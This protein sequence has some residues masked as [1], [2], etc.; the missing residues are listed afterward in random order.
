MIDPPRIELAR[1][2]TPID[3]LQDL[4]TELGVE[5]YVKRDDLTGAALSG[6]KVRK[7]EYVL[8]QALE[9]DADVVLTCGGGQS[10][11]CRATAIAARRVGLDVELFLREARDTPVDGNL[12]LDLLV[13]AAIHNLTDT[14]YADVDQIMADRA[15][16]LGAQGRDAYVIPEGAS[17]A[18]GSLGYVRCM[19]EIRAEEDDADLRFDV[20]VVPVGSG[21]T[22]AG[23][24]AGAQ[25]FGF[26]GRIIGIP[27]C[28]DA[29]T[30][31]VSVGGLLED[32]RRDHLPDLDPT[33]P[34]ETLLDGFVGEG[35]AK[36]THEDLERI[37]DLAVLTG[38]ILD[39]VYTNKAFGALLSLIRAGSIADGERALFIHTGGLFGLFPFGDQM[40]HLMVP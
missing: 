12:F 23:L 5:L 33:L 34:Q 35:Y 8:A 18:L 9:R 21:G 27:V 16:Q 19:E 2:P 13:G 20:L 29:A 38:L 15:A 1:L 30:F 39:P 10:N 28:H 3:H 32:L 17:N 4:S 14:D 22:L 37:R 11:H 26:T 6:N 40:P 31:E 36:A 7:L 24:I 25:Q